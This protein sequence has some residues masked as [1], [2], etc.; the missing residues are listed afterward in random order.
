MRPLVTRREAISLAACGASC[1]ALAGCAYDMSSQGAQAPASTDAATGPSDVEGSG[2]APIQVTSPDTILARMTLEQKVC[3]L[4]C[5]TPEQLVNAD[6]HQVSTDAD[7]GV[8]TGDDLVCTEA[9]DR[10]RQ[11]V[12]AHPV[13]GIC[14]FGRNTTGD[15]QLRS[16]LANTADFSQAAGAGIPAFLA[17][18]EEGGPLVAR[19]A[20]SGCFDVTRFPSMRRIGETGDASKAAEVGST[21]GAYLRD[22]GFNLDFAPCAGVLTNS[23][24]KAIGSRSFGSD[25]ELVASMVAA[26]VQAFGPTGCGCC[27]KHFPGLGGIDEDTHTGAVTSD[28]TA[29]ELRSCEYLPFEAAISAGVPLVMAGHV[30]LPAV[31]GDDTPASLS[32]AMVTG[33]LRGELGFEGVVITDSLS[34]GAITTRFS[35]AEAAKAVLAAGGDMLLMPEDF[36]DAYQGVLDAV[37]SGELAVGRIDESVR[38]I[39]AAKITIGL[40]AV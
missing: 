1:L 40:I 27:A 29:D 16:L 5:V 32:S 19:V 38:R 25:P 33:A 31:T 8:D 9:G 12:E 37:A 3:Q 2:H 4:F 22:I 34:M 28:R 35:A 6:V 36:A 17:V 10:T 26:E 21:I 24:N 15:E 7:N 30:S 20:N 18:D 14:Y 23:G 11:A 39:L 13:G